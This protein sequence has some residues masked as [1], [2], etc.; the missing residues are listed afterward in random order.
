[1]RN[2]CQRIRGALVVAA[3]LAAAPL[4]HAAFQ[5]EEVYSNADGTV[6]F[7]VLHETAG[8]NDLQS[9]RGL[10]LTSVHAGVPAKTYLFTNDLPSSQTAGKRVLIGTRSFAALGLVVPDYVIPD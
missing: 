7:I 3:L 4:A 8:T 1:M 2:A 5:F 6:Q 9:L 10:A